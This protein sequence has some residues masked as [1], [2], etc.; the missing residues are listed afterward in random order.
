ML[1]QDIKQPVV[2]YSLL[3]RPK[4]VPVFDKWSVPDRQTGYTALGE[5]NP[6]RHWNFIEVIIQ[7]ASQDFV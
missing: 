1:S 6:E 2:V 7:E 5:L 4:D 3:C